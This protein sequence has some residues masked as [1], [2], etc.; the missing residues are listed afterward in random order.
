MDDPFLFSS[1]FQH[2]LSPSSLLSKAMFDSQLKRISNNMVAATMRELA[3]QRRLASGHL[4]TMLPDMLPD[5]HHITFTTPPTT[6]TKQ[7]RGGGGGKMKLRSARTS[8][9]YVSGVGA[10]GKLYER[11]EVIQSDST[12]KKK[13]V[14]KHAIEGSVKTISWECLP[15]QLEA[16]CL[17]TVTYDNT[18]EKDLFDAN[19]SK[20]GEFVR[21]C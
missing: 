7:L 15:G 12:T 3:A 16:D 1:Q 5:M 18:G 19:W 4:S 6:H 9:H 10:D 8:H 17:H 20:Y 14:V 21:R 11:D 13:H 2:S